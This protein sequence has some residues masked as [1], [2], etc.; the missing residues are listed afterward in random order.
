MKFGF[1]QVQISEVDKYKT[2]FTTPFGHYEWNVM[3]YGL[4]NAP[5]KFQNIMNDTLIPLVLP[6]SFALMTS[7]STPNPLMNTRN[8]CIHFLISSSIMV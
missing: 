7:L 2:A 1:L 4:K 8:I 6:P 5:R 3:P